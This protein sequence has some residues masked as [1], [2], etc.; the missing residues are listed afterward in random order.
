M[1]SC[2]IMSHVTVRVAKLLVDN[3]NKL[4]ISAFETFRVKDIQVM[5]LAF[6]GHVTS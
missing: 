1:W 5:A 3:L 4:S 6:W 2:D